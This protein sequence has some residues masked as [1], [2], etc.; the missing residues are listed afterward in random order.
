M[1]IKKINVKSFGKLKNKEIELKDGLN[2]IYGE[3]ESGKSTLQSFIKVMLYGVCNKK[4]KKTLSDRAKYTPLGESSFSGE[5]LIE[6]NG[7]EILID[8]S[9]GKTKKYDDG[10]ILN[11]ITGEK[12]N[13]YS[14]QETGKDIL[15]ISSEGFKNT[16]FISQMG[17]TVESSKQDDVLNKIINILECGADEVSYK[18]IK[19]NLEENKKSLTNSRKTGKLDLLRIKESELLEERYKRVKIHEENIENELYLKGL[20][21]K[22]TDLNLKIEEL[23]LHKR[24][25]KKSEL[26]NE[27]EN[28]NEYLNKKEKLEEELKALLEE[29]KDVQA[30]CDLK[31]LNNLR[32][33]FKNYEFLKESLKEKEDKI[34]KLKESIYEYNEKLKSYGILNEISNNLET[35][36][37]ELRIED[38]RLR[39]NYKVIKKVKEELYQ[40]NEKKDDFLSHLNALKLNDNLVLQIE[41]DLEKYNNEK[42]YPSIN[43][44]LK[45]EKNIIEEESKSFSRK[46]FL[47]RVGEVISIL[48]CAFL[49]ISY[50]KSE[51]IIT[52]ALSILGMLL[53]IFLLAK[54][55]LNKKE[56]DN[57]SKRINEIDELINEKKEI[58]VLKSKIDEYKQFLKVKDEYSIKETLEDY[59]FIKKE[60]DILYVE[61][62]EKE[63]SLVLLKED[64]T[65]EKILSN[66]AFIDK[67]LRVTGVASI[68]EILE[69]S[70]EKKSQE[71]LLI[72]KKSEFN[73][74]KEDLNQLNNRRLEIEVKIKAY[75]E[76][77]SLQG[78]N[79]DEVYSRLEEIEAKIEYK[80]SLKNKLSS[81]EEN[82]NLL[83]KGRDILEVKNGLLY[84]ESEVGNEVYNSEEEILNE[85]KLK[86]NDLLNIEKEIKD[87][88]YLI[89]SKELTCRSLFLIDE[90]IAEV[91]G[92][93][94]SLEKKLKG[95]E[96][97]TNY[98]EKA[99]KELQKSFG[100]VINKKV[101]DIFKDVTKGAYKDL[102]VS[103]DYNLVVKD[104]KSNKI[105]DAS[106]LSSGTYDQIYLALRLGI[107]DI[108]FE[109]KKVPIIL[110]ESFTQY[111]DNRLKT[112]LDI[113]YKRVYRNQI[114]LF[115]CQKREI[116][117]LKDK[118]NV[119]IIEL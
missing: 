79:L 37:I 20:K 107:I 80:E 42:I 69:L 110:D 94:K 70:R 43:V 71:D 17:C 24:N 40:L 66:E 88:E 99:F 15:N 57:I 67:L 9:F 48:L 45:D 108:I 100:P 86:N 97:A 111:D 59:R 104:T 65:K 21:E 23:E 49:F 36:L 18:K 93:I 4:G 78:I 56:K 101:E 103:E 51:N 52:L 55:S 25:L 27:Y 19:N 3:N 91:K 29:L 34:D 58:E 117:I 30:I 115:T 92:K 13:K 82:C 105:M 61:I 85:I 14:W 114:I 47:F 39:E 84:E 62:K 26:K 1:I 118:E 6:E 64:E 109:D 38:D 77:T 2:I 72:R 119:N 63:K 8:R 7:E 89:S 87:V 112:M 73:E 90:E 28:I 32:D 113:I 60:L 5:L 98:M 83:L 102:R 116:N 12:I 53:F 75:L 22:R 35:K 31:K 95:I 44:N 41:K 81:V 10:N 96:I 33:E 54:S 11:N 106:Y 50:F 16:L 74:A 76:N 46:I 68:E